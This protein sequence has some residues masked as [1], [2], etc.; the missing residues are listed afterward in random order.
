MNASRVSPE[1]ETSAVDRL[2]KAKKGAV[3]FVE[4]PTFA[5]A[6]VHGEGAPEAG[7]FQEAIEALYSVTYTIHFAM[8]K[9]RGDAPRVMPLEALWWVDGDREQ[10]VVRAATHRRAILADVDRSRWRWT[11]MIMQPPPV[12]RTWFLSAIDEVRTNKDLAG[13]DRVR[14]EQWRE[15]PAAQ[16]LHVGPYADEGP[17]IVALHDAIAAAGA[18]P[19]GKHHEIYLGDPRRAAPERRRTILRQPIATMPVL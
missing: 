1:T 8:K 13:L 10:E 18:E 16:I 19:R 14:F 2:Y 9:A 3:T 7:L 4:V 12:D 17:T 11:A 5:W 15:G 6:M